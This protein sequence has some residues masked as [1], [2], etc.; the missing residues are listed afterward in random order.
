MEIGDIFVINKAD[1]DGADRRYVELQAALN[2]GERQ[3]S[4]DPP[5]L[6]TIASSGEGVEELVTA[7]QAHHTHLMESG[8]IQ[9]NLERR[10]SAQLETIVEHSFIRK[11]FVQTEEREYFLH[12]VRKVSAREID[13]YTAAEL[14][15]LRLVQPSKVG[16]SS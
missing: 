3:Q 16:E 10:C 4:W 13:P 12:L 8:E 5:I 6:K 15:I 7:I 9:Q 14:L 2:L 11:L 1:L